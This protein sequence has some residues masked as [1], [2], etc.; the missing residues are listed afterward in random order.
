MFKEILSKSTKQ[1]V[2][3][4]IP[5]LL[6]LFLIINATTIE[7]KAIGFILLAGS[8]FYL[9][10]DNLKSPI[11]LVAT[12]IGVSTISI[13]FGMPFEEKY[14]GMFNL[15]TSM[16]LFIYFAVLG[17]GY[18]IKKEE[19]GKFIYAFISSILFIIIFGLV[20]ENEI[21]K[22]NFNI[23]AIILSILIIGANIVLFK[24]INKE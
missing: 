22:D 11:L 3:T 2:L 16:M 1:I 4:L 23:F 5:I 20:L 8:I 21:I 19:Q 6:A 9:F 15:I 14:T 24:T 10:T 13:K 7:L 18:A 17:S 12:L